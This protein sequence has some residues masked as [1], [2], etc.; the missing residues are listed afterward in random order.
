MYYPTFYDDDNIYDNSYDDDNIYMWKD[1]NINLTSSITMNNFEHK[2]LY[3]LYI[4]FYV[5]T[6]RDPFTNGSIIY[7]A[8]SNPQFCPFRKRL[9]MNELA[10]KVQ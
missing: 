2:F 5:M 1:T 4:P 3:C 9:I 8:R 10:W 7:S 6:S